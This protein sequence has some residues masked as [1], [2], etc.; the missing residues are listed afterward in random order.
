VTR[1]NSRTCKKKKGKRSSS[2]SSENFR[3]FL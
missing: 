1:R 2:R 3:S